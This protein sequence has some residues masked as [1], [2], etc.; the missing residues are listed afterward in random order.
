MGLLKVYLDYMEE[1]IS[2]TVGQL[3]GKTMMELGDQ[4]I[5]GDGLPEKTGKEYFEHRGVVH[6]SV[7]LN[8]MRGAIK[9]D[10]AKPATNFEWFNHFDIVTNS[11]TTEHVEPKSGQYVCFKNIHNWLTVGG[12]AI[13]LLP[14]I[15]EME[16]RG[17]WKNHSNN[18]Y[19]HDFFRML[20]RRNDYEIVNMRI[21]NGL[22]CVCLKKTRDV[23]FMDDHAEF[24]AGIARREGG[25]VYDN[26]NDSLTRRV[27][28]APYLAARKIYH[29][30]GLK[31]FLQSF[32]NR[33]G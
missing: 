33:Q 30:L 14:D 10:L 12:I 6:T 19:S 23:P 1:C 15:D 28:R 21:I 2:S 20:A 25:I 32:K 13:H 16:Q 26:I 22:I 7:D 24:L 9:V 18:Y 27:L 11:G 3:N 29:V 5:M 17:H 8:G 4:E 31:N